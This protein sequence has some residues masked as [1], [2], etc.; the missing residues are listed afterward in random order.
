[1]KFEERKVVLFVNA[2]ALLEMK[3]TTGILFLFFLLTPT[4][5]IT[6]GSL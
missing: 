5:L 1:M 2:F 4:C 3:Y 6:S